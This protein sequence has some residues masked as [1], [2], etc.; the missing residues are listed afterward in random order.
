MS[1]F[2]RIGRLL[3]L[4]FSI[5]VEGIEESVP[6]ERRLAYDR[7]ERSAK[8]R[9]MMDKATDVGE[10]AEM[11]VQGLAE[12]RI[13][14]ANIQDQVRAHLQAAKAAQVRGD[15]ATEE[16]QRASAAALADDLAEAHH[17]VSELEQMVGEAMRDREESKQMVLRQ[18]RELERLSRRDSRLV[19]RVRMTEMKAESLQLREALLEL[20]PEDAD[21][22]RQRALE[23][24]RRR[25]VRAK[26]RSEIVDALWQQKR[27]GQIALDMQTTARG[28]QIL[29]QLEK[30]VGYEPAS[31][32]ASLEEK[33]SEQEAQQA[34]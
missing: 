1:I 8:L 6:L 11:M 22:F 21:N 28:A 24:V 20:V 5:F 15:S 3:R 27:R 30:E 12:T 29:R 9:Q 14:V 19:A 16:D 18:A 32:P 31:Q 10:A 4:F 2:K 33:E 13:I 23:G 25:E 34:S 17:E 7:Q 26:A